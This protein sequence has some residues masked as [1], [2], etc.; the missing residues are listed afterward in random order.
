MGG[1][2]HIGMKSWFQGHLSQ[3]KCWYFTLPHRLDCVSDIS[4]IVQIHPTSSADEQ[5]V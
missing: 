4:I 2:S 3:L 5:A 1:T